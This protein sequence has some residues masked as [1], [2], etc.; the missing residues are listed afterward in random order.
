MYTFDK[1]ATS[2]SLLKLDLFRGN[3]HYSVHL[4]TLGASPIFTEDVYVYLQICVWR[5]RSKLSKGWFISILIL[6]YLQ[7]PIVSKT[8]GSQCLLNE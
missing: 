1:T 2:L 3:H 6:L 5:F 7:C 8:A 4:E